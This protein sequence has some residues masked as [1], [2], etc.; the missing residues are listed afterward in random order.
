MVF[1]DPVS[2]ERDRKTWWG[3]RWYRDTRGLCFL[4]SRT[5]LQGACAALRGRD[6]LRSS[7]EATGLRLTVTLPCNSTMG[8]VQ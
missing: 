8:V 2:D 5:Y 1:T 4:S 7:N 6:Y 3:Y